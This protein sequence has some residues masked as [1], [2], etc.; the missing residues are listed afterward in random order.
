MNVKTQ[1]LAI[2]MPRAQTPMDLTFVDVNIVTQ[3]MGKVALGIEVGLVNS[4]E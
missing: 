2:A 3:V 1:D 4:A